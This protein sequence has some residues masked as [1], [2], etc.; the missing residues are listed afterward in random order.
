MVVQSNIETETKEV[1]FYRLEDPSAKDNGCWCV[2][3]TNRV[4]ITINDISRLFQL[5]PY[6]TSDVSGFF[7]DLP[8]L[9][10]ATERWDKLFQLEG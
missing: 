6:L 4:A 7:P 1:D 3:G 9:F 2:I 8:V 5:Q 10:V